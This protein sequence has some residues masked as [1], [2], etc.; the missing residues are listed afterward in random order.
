MREIFEVKIN[1]TNFHRNQSASV[2]LEKNMLIFPYCSVHNGFLKLSQTAAQN[3]NKY[4][5]HIFYRQCDNFNDKNKGL[6]N[7]SDEGRQCTRLP[8]SFGKGNSSKIFIT[9]LIEITQ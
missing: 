5:L 6:E 7:Y 1:I 8:H 3:Y 9:R 2:G 4:S